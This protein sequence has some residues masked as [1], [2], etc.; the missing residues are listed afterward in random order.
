MHQEFKTRHNYLVTSLLS[1][2]F[3]FSLRVPWFS[4]GVLYTGL[5]A[6]QN[7]ARALEKVGEGEGGMGL[8]SKFSG[9]GRNQWSGLS[10]VWDVARSHCPLHSATLIKM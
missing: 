4:P 5:H 9:G 10:M 8:F 6:K 2:N 7:R 1:E 3:M